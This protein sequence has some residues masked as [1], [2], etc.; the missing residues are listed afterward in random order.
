MRKFFLALTVLS[1]FAISGCGGGSSSSIRSTPPISPDV[2]QV[3]MLSSP[4]LERNKRYRIYTGSRLTGMN[5]ARY[6]VANTGSEAVQ[7]TLNLGFSIVL[8]S[9]APF[10]IVNDAPDSADHSG[11]VVFAYDPSAA[12][13]SFTS[14]GNV[15]F[16]G[17]YLM[18]YR[19]LSLSESAETADDTVGHYVI[20]P[21][22]A[23][24]YKQ[25]TSSRG[26]TTFAEGSGSSLSFVAD[27]EEDYQPRDIPTSGFVLRTVRKVNT[28]SGIVRQY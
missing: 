23:D 17:G 20:R 6:Y 1:V 10:I 2:K 12:N 19:T 15:A 3:I 22:D 21:Q 18:R 7:S 5:G 14:G 8:S 24:I 13:D 26:T 16:S 28:F 4:A 25:Y 27:D 9:D 11:S